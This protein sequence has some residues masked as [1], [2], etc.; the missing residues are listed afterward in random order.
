ML[1]NRIGYS[2][3]VKTCLGC[4]ALAL[5]SGKQR[6]CARVLLFFVVFADC[7]GSLWRNAR[8]TVDNDAMLRTEHSI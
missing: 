5:A 2:R 6:R 8:F 1:E 4:S 3:I 7:L